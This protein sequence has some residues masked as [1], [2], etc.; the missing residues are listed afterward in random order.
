MIN[1]EEREYYETKDD[2]VDNFDQLNEI[3]RKDSKWIE[4]EVYSEVKIGLI[5][6]FR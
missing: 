3:Y 5:I 1:D 2:V 4:K 6:D